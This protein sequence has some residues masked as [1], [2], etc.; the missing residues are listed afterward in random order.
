MHWMPLAGGLLTAGLAARLSSSR[1]F[2]LLDSGTDAL[3]MALNAVVLAFLASTL[4][5]GALFALQGHRKRTEIWNAVL[6]AAAGAVWLVPVVLLLD[7]GSSWAAVPAIL[8]V[9]SLVRP[10]RQCWPNLSVDSLPRGDDILTTPL[11]APQ[12]PARG[13]LGI[14]LCL[15]VGFVSAIAHSEHLAAVAFAVSALLLAVGVRTQENSQQGERPAILALLNVAVVLLITA[16]GLVLFFRLGSGSGSE[17]AW[18]VNS[19]S[20][21]PVT[22]EAEEPEGKSS[23]AFTDDEHPGVILFPEVQ[24]RTFLVPPLPAMS[25]RLFNTRRPSPLSIPFYGVYWMYR[26]PNRRPPRNSLVTRGSPV[27]AGFRST[28]HRPLIMEARQGLGRLIDV[29]CCRS[30]EL[31]VSNADRLPGSVAIELILINSTQRGRQQS[32]GVSPVTSIPR[33]RPGYEHGVLPESLTFWVPTASSIEQFDE[34]RIVFRL[35]LI[36][37]TS[38]ARIALDRFVL[39]PKGL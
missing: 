16:A 19:A 28:D 23:G 15:Q 9:V 1:S 36:R 17:S 20:E 13:S 32:L 38:S 34:F 7:V 35:G 11:S 29:S 33:W 21:Q 27:S 3:L 8:L 26:A 12:T 25:S 22:Q 14:A 5:M 24:E 10:I 2:A 37:A 30:I 18:S 39:V 31:V 4:A 6:P